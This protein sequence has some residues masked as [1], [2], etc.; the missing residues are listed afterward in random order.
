MLWD[1]EQ[2]RW[3]DSSQ[4]GRSGRAVGRGDTMSPAPR[5]LCGEAARDSGTDRKR[6]DTGDHLAGDKQAI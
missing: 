2:L 6:E 5:P 4:E 3:G 1:G